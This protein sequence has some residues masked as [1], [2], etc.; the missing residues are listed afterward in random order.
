MRKPMTFATASLLALMALL[1]PSAPAIAMSVQPVVVDLQAA[2]RDMN[3]VVNVQNTSQTPLPVELRIRQVAFAPDGSPI[4]GKDAGDLVVF[5]PQALIQPGQSQTFRIQYVGDPALAAS[6]HYYVTVAQVPVQTPAG[7]SQIQILYNFEVL[8]SV[9]ALGVKPSFQVVSA[10]IGRNEA[11]QPVPIITLTNNSATYGYLSRGRLRI[12][13]KDRN[14]KTV[15][16]KTFSA[17]EIQQT[18]GMGL[19]ASGQTRQFAVPAALPQEGGA[20]EAQFSMEQ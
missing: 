6:K 14:G 1:V 16:S 3:Q 17:A 2:G 12:V 9:G 20:I 4:V 8:V 18:M 5:P 10:Q 7:Q 19:I 11:G 15:F 13:A